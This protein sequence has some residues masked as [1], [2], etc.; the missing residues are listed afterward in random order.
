ANITTASDACW[1]VIVTISTVGYGDKY[2]VTNAGRILGSIIIVVGVG[3]FGT[4]TG[5]LATTFLSSKDKPSE[6]PPTD[7]RRQVARLK[8]LVAQQQVAVDQVE[9]LLQADGR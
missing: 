3:I 2:P 5:Y 6:A 4:F 1:Y 9:V 8:E 7:A